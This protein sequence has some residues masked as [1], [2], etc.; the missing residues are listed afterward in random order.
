DALYESPRWNNKKLRYREHT[1]LSNPHVPE[2][3]W[4]NRLTLTVASRGGFS[5]VETNQTHITLPYGTPMAAVRQIVLEA[6]P[7]VRLVL[8][9]SK[10]LKRLCR[11]LGSEQKNEQFN[12]LANYVLTESSRYCPSEDHGGYNSPPF[13]WQ[14]PFTAYNCTWGFHAP[15]PFPSSYTC[16]DPSV[17]QTAA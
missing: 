4:R 13:D 6:N 14:N 2:T 12:S 9:K 7:A 10:H 1:F 3:V 5:S 8:L 16:E 17:P 11:W 15:A